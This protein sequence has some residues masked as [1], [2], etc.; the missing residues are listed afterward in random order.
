MTDCK[1]EIEQIDGFFFPYAIYRQC[2]E[3]LMLIFNLLEIMYEID[4]KMGEWTKP[5]GLGSDTIRPHEAA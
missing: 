3:S 2:M 1:K 4:V 5:N